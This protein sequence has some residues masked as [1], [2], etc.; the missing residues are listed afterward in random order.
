MDIDQ[1][2]KLDVLGG[3]FDGAIVWAKNLGGGKVAKPLVIKDTQGKK[4]GHQINNDENV[5]MYPY[6]CD[7]DADGDL[8]LLLGGFD[9]TIHLAINQTGKINGYATKLILLKQGKKTIELQG[10][11]CP[12]FV[13]WDKDGKPD[14]VCADEEGEVFL[15]KNEGPKTAPQLAKQTTLLKKTKQANAPQKNLTLEVA[16]FNADGKWDLLVGGISKEK[17]GG[18]WLFAGK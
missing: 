10:H 11:A 8:D 5:C 7:W 14:L 15:Y 12:I 18:V 6:A 16:D 4:V 17:K 3:S 9:G 1:D 2:G 13:D